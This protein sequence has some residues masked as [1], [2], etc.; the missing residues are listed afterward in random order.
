[1]AQRE[2]IALLGTGIMGAAMGR[3]LLGAGFAVRAWNRTRTKAEPLGEAGATVAGSP[4]E[5]AEGATILLTSLAEG[6]AVAE[7]AGPALAALAPHAVWVEAS[8][9]GID[10]VDRL[11]GLAAGHDVAYVDAPVLGTRQP[12]EEGKLTVFAS[13]PAGLADRLEPVF[14][15]IA[16]RTLWLGP[17]GEGTKLKLVVNTWLH[18][19]LG[20][21]AETIAFAR[22]I[23]VDPERFLEAIEGGP[24][25]P[26]YAQLKGT[27]MRDGEYSPASFGAALGGKDVRLTLEAAGDE[28]DLPIVRAT[29][30]AYERVVE[31]GHG[32]DDIAA[33][34]EAARP[35]R[36]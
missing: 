15:A 28:L 17:A 26:A 23:G 34:Y 12:A 18:T 4:A 14:G 9:V 21:L 13:G 33:L 35:D 22:G 11:A 2:T 30:A 27:M 24:L 20:A 10:D 8:T 16:A 36:S 29:A 7:T 31:L 5:A 25:G 3:R 6:S 1:M 32:E 19:M